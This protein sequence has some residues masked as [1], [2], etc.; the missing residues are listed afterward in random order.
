MVLSQA[1]LLPPQFLHLNRKHRVPI[2]KVTKT[3]FN[4]RRKILPSPIMS[5]SQ[6]GEEAADVNRNIATEILKTKLGFSDDEIHRLTGEEISIM[7]EDK[8]VEIPTDEMLAIIEAEIYKLPFSKRIRL[9]KAFNVQEYPF[10]KF[11]VSLFMPTNPREEED[12]KEPVPSA[13]HHFSAP[14]PPQQTRCFLLSIVVPLGIT[15]VFGAICL[16]SSKLMTKGGHLITPAID[17]AQD[18][19]LVETDNQVG[20]VEAISDVTSNYSLN[21]CVAALEEIQDIPEDTYGKA[22]KKFMN[23]DSRK[24]F[25]AMSNESKREWLL[26]L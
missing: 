12:D 16:I 4:C 20:S 22:L 17:V 5:S 19:Q 24:M 15:Y 26:Q 25:I 13:A 10:A 23:P 18:L 21:K 6:R 1:I 14:L 7:M 9:V 2:T 3:S 11:L 8:I